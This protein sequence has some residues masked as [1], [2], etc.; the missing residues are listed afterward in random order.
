LVDENPPIDCKA[1][2]RGKLYV[3]PHP[4]CNDQKVETD[5][6]SALKQGFI[7][8][9]L[10]DAVA[11]VE[12]KPLLLEVVTHLNGGSLIEHAHQ[13]PRGEVNHTDRL[14][15]VKNSLR[16]LQADEACTQ[17]EDTALLLQVGLQALCFIK[18]EEGKPILHLAQPLDRGNEGRRAGCQEQLVVREG[19]FPIQAYRLPLSVDAHCTG[20][21]QHCHL[22]LFIEG[23]SA[24][25][26]AV[27]IGFSLQQV[28]DEGP[29]V[30]RMVLLP[31]NGD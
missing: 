26:H 30:T 22:V 4:D 17:N 3:R 1:C 27:L 14:H 12:P 16:T 6:N 25:F 21:L 18:G 5:D 24:V 31:D 19:C 15:L 2:F 11:Q 9:A 28:G 13:Y 29:A 10:L 8:G 7:G 20:S 23:G